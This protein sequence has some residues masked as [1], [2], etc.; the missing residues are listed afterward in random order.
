M[1]ETGTPFVSRAQD[2]DSNYT[3][4]RKRDMRT[5]KV[6]LRF[7]EDNTH[8]EDTGQSSGCMSLLL[9]EKPDLKCHSQ[10]E[11][12]IRWELRS[13]GSSSPDSQVGS[14]QQSLG[15]TRG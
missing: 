1:E 14:S 3:E 6:R 10:R 2:N 11:R 9:D 15:Y 4:D 8:T 7:L 5:D 13:S 12:G